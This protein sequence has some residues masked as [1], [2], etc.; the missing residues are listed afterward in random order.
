MI[1]I[2]RIWILKIKLNNVYSSTFWPCSFTQTNPLRLDNFNGNVY[3]LT[4]IIMSWY[5]KKKTKHK[6]THNDLYLKPC[7][8]TTKY[9]NPRDQTQDVRV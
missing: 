5:F 6:S 3:L 9:M 7:I 1:Q 4:F 2:S 8:L